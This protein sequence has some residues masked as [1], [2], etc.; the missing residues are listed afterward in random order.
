M[1]LTVPSR[2]V[3]SPLHPPWIDRSFLSR[4][5]YR[6][7]L[8]KRAKL[9]NSTLDWSAYRSFRNKSLSYCRSL[10]FKFFNRLSSSPDSHH[11]WSTLKK[12]RKKSSSIPPLLS[13]SGCLVHSD[14][15]KANLLNE[16]FSSCF[17]TS[18][19]PFNPSPNSVA[20][21]CPPNLLCST[22]NV[23]HLLLLLPSDTATGPD[24]LSSR[25]LK[26]TAHSILRLLSLVSLIFLFSLVLFP[27]IGNALILSPFPKLT[28]LPLLLISVLFLFF[29]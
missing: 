16:F 10:K 24:G 1:H 9:S 6:N 5:K 4:I 25:M 15:S 7:F 26:A 28:L 22:D 11:F 2:F 14:L 27:L 13:R 3:S 29:L 18:S 12:F 23:L 8:F 20:S 19:P 17:N 21:L